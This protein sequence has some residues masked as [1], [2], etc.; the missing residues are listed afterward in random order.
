MLKVPNLRSFWSVPMPFYLIV[1]VF[2]SFETIN[3]GS[4]DCFY[5]GSSGTTKMT[6]K[7][8]TD[9]TQPV[10]TDLDKKLDPK[11]KTLQTWIFMH[12]GLKNKEWKSSNMG[13]RSYQPTS[14]GWS[15]NHRQIGRHWFAGNSYF[16]CERIFISSFSELFGINIEGLNSLLL[17]HQLFI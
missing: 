12:K 2:W 5:K 7:E 17:G 1:A 9:V 4:D 8:K 10:K 16:P 11:Q 15:A 6:F 3:F 14:A 13:N